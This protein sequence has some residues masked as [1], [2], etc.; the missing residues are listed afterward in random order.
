VADEIEFKLNSSF[1]NQLKYTQNSE[2]SVKKIQCILEV[3][4][5]HYGS[6]DCYVQEDFYFDTQDKALVKERNSLR[7]RYAEGKAPMI[8]SKHFFTYSTNGQHHR[9]EDEKEIKPGD[10][11][12][13]ALLEHA[14]CYFSKMTIEARPVVKIKNSRTS[15]NI[16]TDTANYLFCLDKFHFIN[17][18]DLTRSDDYYEIEVEDISPVENSERKESQKEDSQMK[19]LV[20]IFKK[21]FEF[22]PTE[23]NKYAKGVDWLHEPIAQKDMQYMEFDIVDYSSKNTPTQKSMIKN[24]TRMV[25]A[26]LQECDAN[27]CLKIPIGDGVI[28]SIDDRSDK[29]LKIIQKMSKKLHDHNDRFPHLKFH[30]RSAVHYGHILMYQDINNNSNLAGNGINTVARIISKAEEGQI[31]I[32]DAWYNNYKDMG[33]ISDHLSSCFSEPFKIK[34]K[35]NVSIPVRNFHDDSCGIEHKYGSANTEV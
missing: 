22:T 6:H 16:K 11:D 33:I 35:H 10:D 4:G 5:I 18:A 14:K 30:L 29:V 8:T 20:A 13:R 7:I 19:N 27:D 15:F 31:L 12:I 34:V 23:K 9:Q 21:I 32:S 26:S 28:L 2:P 3:L 25:L 24:F 17:P 1:N